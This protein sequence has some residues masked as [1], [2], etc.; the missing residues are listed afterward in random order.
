[1][2]EF[3]GW[4]GGPAPTGPGTVA[5]SPPAAD[6]S[7]DGGFSAAQPIPARRETSA[8]VAAD[9]SW[10]WAWAVAVGVMAAPATV[11]RPSARAARV[12]KLSPKSR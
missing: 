6:A 12:R 3:W 9:T 1:M 11:A 8:E 10:A 4:F 7:G 5:P 2:F